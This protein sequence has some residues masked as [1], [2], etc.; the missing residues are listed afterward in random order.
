MVFDRQEWI[1]EWV[2]DHKEEQKDGT[3]RIEIGD[4]AVIL[5]N[6]Q[7]ADDFLYPIALEEYEFYMTGD[8]GI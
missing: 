6:D 7:D 5:E 4:D 8:L 3:I 2:Q 1:L